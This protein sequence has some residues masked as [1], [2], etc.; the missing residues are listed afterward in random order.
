LTQQREMGSVTQLRDRRFD[1]YAIQAKSP[2]Q[3]VRTV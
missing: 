1:L 2:V 3:I